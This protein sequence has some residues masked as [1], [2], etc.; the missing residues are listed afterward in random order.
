MAKLIISIGSVPNDGTGD[1]LRDG[2]DKINQNFDELYDVS[3][4]DPGSLPPTGTVG[5]IYFTK[6][7]KS[8]YSWNG[9]SY[10]LEGGLGLDA[11]AIHDNVSGEIN[12]IT[13]K[14]TPVDDDVILIEDSADSYNKKKVKKSNF[15]DDKAIHDNVSGEINAISEKTATVND[16]III[17]EDS[18]DSF[19]KKKVKKSNFAGA[20]GTF[21]LWEEVADTVAYA[22]TST[23][24]ATG[25]D[26]T[27]KRGSSLK[28]NTTSRPT[29]RIVDVNF[30]GGNSTVTVAGEEVPNPINSMYIDNGNATPYVPE[31]LVAW[32]G[33]YNSSDTTNIQELATND[34]NYRHA[35]VPFWITQI[36]NKFEDAG[37]N[38]G[39]GKW[40]I[41]ID[42]YNQTSGTLNIGSNYI[43]LDISGGANFTNVG[44]G[45]NIVGDSFVATGNYS[46]FM[47]D[48]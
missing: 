31:S 30:S 27:E 21:E 19:N 6:T 7:T 41:Y 37:T 5:L 18:E 23:F 47:G 13:E 38:S 28:I 24:T 10:D 16:D 42:T 14:T 12:A 40:N 34:F 36:I 2:G 22:S 35:Q 26:Y 44:A 11:D 32:N 3:V 15:S 4:N 9:S 43:I 25:V 48:W 1:T 45:A 17:I 39:N 33:S 20:G 46:N 29:N 8:F